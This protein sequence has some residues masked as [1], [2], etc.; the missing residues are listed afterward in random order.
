MTGRVSTEQYFIQDERDCRLA[1]ARATL[2]RDARS[3]L[4]YRVAR[5]DGRP[6]RLEFHRGILSR[7]HVGEPC[8]ANDRL[9]CVEFQP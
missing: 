4:P 9:S 6:G 1:G 7:R 2:V 8:D 3:S 5:R